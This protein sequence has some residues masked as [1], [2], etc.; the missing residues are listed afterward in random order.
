MCSNANNFNSNNVLSI[1][2]YETLKEQPPRDERNFIDVDLCIHIEA[3]S[4]IYTRDLYRISL[5]SRLGLL[6]A[7]PASQRKSS[8]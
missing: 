5:L 6:N 3:I 4:S 1:E 7:P 2:R 8:N